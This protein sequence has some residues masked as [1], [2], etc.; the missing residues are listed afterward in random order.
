MGETPTYTHLN[1][2]IYFRVSRDLE[3]TDRGYQTPKKIYDMRYFPPNLAD[4][5]QGH[6][7]KSPFLGSWDHFSL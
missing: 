1:K 7:M 5:D 4:H 6:H 2:F 3:Y